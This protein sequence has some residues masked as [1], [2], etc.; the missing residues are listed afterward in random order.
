MQPRHEVADIL[1]RYGHTFRQ[2]Y[3]LPAH[4][5]RTLGALE[6]CRTAALGGH[7]DACTACGAVRISY[8][9]CRNRH[10]PKCQNTNR[11]QWLMDREAELLPVP[12]F[13]LV[14]T[15]PHA[16]NELCMHHPKAMYGML[17]RSAWQTVEGFGW[18]PKF[19]GAE[20]GMISILHT[21]GQNLSLHP[22]IHCIIPGGGI[23]ATGKWKAARNK[24]KYLFPVKDKGMSSVFRAKYIGH[25]RQWAKSKGVQIDDE[26]F[27]QCFEKPWVV[28]AKQAFKG[29]EGVMEY[30][31]R[32]SHKIA[33]SNHRLLDI[34][35]NKVQ[36][37]WKDYRTGKN[38]VMA[39]DA[40]EFLRR[41]CQHILPK[42]FP[43]IR[44]YG[45]LA[46]R[47]K[48][49]K[50]A[51]A[52]QSMG[53][54]P[55]PPKEKSTWQELSKERLGFDPDQCP[56]CGGRMQEVEKLLPERGPPHPLHPKT[57][58]A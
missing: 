57:R 17:F 38:K 45:L 33:I 46:S 28:Y 50:L 49:D 6:Q 13:H 48:A 37:K 5:L 2:Q 43:R 8:N 26:V 35:N 51:M 53:V 1:K 12:Y 4:H 22:H 56:H 16:L 9:S 7:V 31:G 18:N 23:S 15:L 55:A 29:P 52:R 41:F 14:F 36:F 34:E 32:Y 20:T 19:L 47:G 24:G 21:W 11:E 3:K 58:K 10:C 40:H 42:G 30:L 25:L 39:L 44:H 54:P 27:K